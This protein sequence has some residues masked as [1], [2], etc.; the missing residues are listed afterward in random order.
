L[1]NI[2]NS[3]LAA[4]AIDKLREGIKT[5]HKATIIEAYNMIEIDNFSWEEI[6][7]MYLEWDNLIDDANDIIYN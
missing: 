2:S 7:T 5:K 4:S 1:K 3:D 6:D